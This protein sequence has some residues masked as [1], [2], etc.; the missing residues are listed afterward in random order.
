MKTYQV[1]INNQEVEVFN[2]KKF[3]TSISYAIANLMTLND[4]KGSTSKVIDLPA[5]A[6]NKIIFG[7][8]EDFNAAARISHSEKPNAVVKADGTPILRGFAKI[9][10]AT[11]NGVITKYQLVIQGDNGDWR[12]RIKGK[13]AQEL[14][15]S[16]QDHTLDLATVQASETLSA[17]REYVYDLIDRGKFAS[18][19]QGGFPVLNNSNVQLYTIPEGVKVD[20]RYPAIRVPGLVRRIFKAQGYKVVSNWLDAA[21]AQKLTIGFTGKFVHDLDFNEN[22]KFHATNILPWDVTVGP[23]ALSSS[24]VNSYTQE[25]SDPSN[26]WN[27]GYY[28]KVPSD[29]QYK[30]KAVNIIQPGPYTVSAS[31]TVYVSILKIDAATAALNPFAQGTVIAQANCSFPA[32]ATVTIETSLLNLN[33]GD[34]IMV[35]TSLY[36]NASTGNFERVNVGVG[37]TFECTEVA[38]NLSVQE[39]QPVNMTINLPDFQQTQILQGIA[40]PYKLMFATDVEARVVYIEP[41]EDFFSETVKAENNWTDLLDKTKAY[42]TKFIGDQR[43]KV[44]HYAWKEDSNDKFVAAW[45]DQNSS[46]F[47][48]SKEDNLNAFAKSE[49]EMNVN[50]FFAPTWMDVCNEAGFITARIPRMWSDVTRPGKSTGF[51]PRLLV[52]QGAQNMPGDEQWAE[53]SDSGV[54][55]RDTYPSFEFYNVDAQN[56]DNLLFSDLDLSSGLF[57]KQWRNHHKTI[58]EGVLFTG[59]FNLTDQRIS[60]FDFREPIYLE[61]N[62]SGAYFLVNEIRNYKADSRESTEVELLKIFGKTPRI[63]LRKVGNPA[64]TSTVAAGPSSPASLDVISVVVTDSRGG[65]RTQTYQSFRYQGNEIF[66]VQDEQVRTGGGNVY[67][68][69]SGMFHQVFF[70]DDNGNVQ[71]VLKD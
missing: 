40:Q 37:S 20:D 8:P 16:D 45:N 33:H 35:Q 4:T 18:S 61:V 31:G 34:R 22:Q 38:G 7:T 46:L 26:N 50:P 29:G 12:A 25:D 2:R 23:S 69:I 59:F 66:R 32:Y 47:G 42:G 56:E 3:G 68:E 28:Y 9:N 53:T 39:G 43:G 41:W 1:I 65:G 24:R 67:V 70:E 13:K 17:S 48:S 21:H 52:Y 10:A 19:Q 60:K 71:P 57:Q 55:M 49:T 63:L 15:Y 64:A 58:T 62:H 30:F 36:L 54:T 14:D 44:I 11:V 5:T 27:T 51:A 6:Q